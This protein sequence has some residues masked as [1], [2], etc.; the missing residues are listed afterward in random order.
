[1]PLSAGVNSVKRPTASNV[2]LGV[3]RAADSS[4]LV[5]AALVFLPYLSRVL[6]MGDT[7]EVQNVGEGGST[8][9]V[10]ENPV[11]PLYFMA[12]FTAGL[13]FVSLFKGRWFL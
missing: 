1:M 5:F 7:Y 13:L 12:G 11:E 3:S 2:F 6:K 10:P 4:S 8:S 9:T